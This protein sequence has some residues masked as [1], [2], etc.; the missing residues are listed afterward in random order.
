MNRSFT[1]ILIKPDAFFTDVMGEN[2][3]F[4]LP[5]II[6]LAGGIIGA[7]YGYMIGGL[8]ARMMSGA[9]PGIDMIM[10]LVSAL[11]ALFGVFVFWFIWTGIIYLISAAFKGKGSFRRTLQV[12]GYGYLPQVFGSLLSLIVAIEYIPRIVV[13][14]I[15]VA[16]MQ[17]PVV[18]Q[19][20][21]K[22]LMH[23]PAMLE[24]TQIT[25]VITIV[26]FLWSANIWIFGVRHARGI[27]IRDA[28]LSVGIPVIIY[29]AY[30]VYTLG[31][32]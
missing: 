20:V 7:G 1:D 23:D 5:L 26:F 31:A 32:V 17:D 12:T 29:V 21:T 16:M 18:M 14:Q 11:G 9:I 19:E 6:L 3:N 28:A 13:P 2:E 10:T 15:T 25:S 4:K 24:L 30:I 22:A 8:T 27:T